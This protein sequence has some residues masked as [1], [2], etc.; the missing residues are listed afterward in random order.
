MD[1]S[2]G[3]SSKLVED[4]EIGVGK[5]AGDLTCLALSLFLFERVD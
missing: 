1:H 5:P 2:E 4:H 3:G